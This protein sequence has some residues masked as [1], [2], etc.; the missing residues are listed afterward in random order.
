[1]RIESGC[2]GGRKYGRKCV[3]FCQRVFGAHEF[4]D[5]ALSSLDPTSSASDANI[6]KPK[7]PGAT[8]IQFIA[9]SISSP[10]ANEA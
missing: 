9:Q 8:Q 10:S 3:Q 7:N 2:I 6:R 4:Y 5:I 1:M